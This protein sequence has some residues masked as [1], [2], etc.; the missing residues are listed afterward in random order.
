MFAQA[1]M[2]RKRIFSNVF[3][4]SATILD[5]KHGL[6]C[7]EERWKGLRPVFFGP[8]SRISCT[9]RDQRM[10]VRLSLRKAA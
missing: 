9:T 4:Q 5:L 7:V 2:G 6:F 1:Y 8:W 3:A 10:R